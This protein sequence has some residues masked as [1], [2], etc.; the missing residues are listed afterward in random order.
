MIA[1]FQANMPT[2]ALK[3]I[4]NGIIREEDRMATEGIEQLN[5]EAQLILRNKVESQLLS[6]I[7]RILRKVIN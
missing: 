7:R 5:Q 3:A 6:L 1:A 4:V 2:A